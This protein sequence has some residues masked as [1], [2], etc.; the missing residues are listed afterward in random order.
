MPVATTTCMI[1]KGVQVVVQC[2]LAAETGCCPP[3][4]NLPPSYCTRV[5]ALRAATS[6]GVCIEVLVGRGGG[7][8]VL[9][10]GFHYIYLVFMWGECSFM[11][12]ISLH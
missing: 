10:G 2:W 1:K 5:A 9:C 6:I 12:G 7:I 8:V 11:W 4:S 3:G